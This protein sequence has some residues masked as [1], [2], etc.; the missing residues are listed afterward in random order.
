MK[1]IIEGPAFEGLD[2]LE[3][4]DVIWLNGRVVTVRDVGY[5][6]IVEKNE[7][8]PVDLSGSA[9]FH[10]GPIVRK[11]N[12]RWELI[13]IGPT[14]SMRMEKFSYEFIR[15]TKAKIII[16]KGGMGEETERACI[17]FGSIHCI[18]P[19]GCAVLCARQVER[20]EEVKWEN[21]GMPEAMY[22]MKVR[23]FG[24]LI[25]SIDTKGNNLIRER[26]K[27]LKSKMERSIQKV[28][29]F[30]KDMA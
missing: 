21:L 7:E 24:P 23:E 25:V 2:S 10:A 16:G 17:Q 13:S 26:K 12:G 20:I 14:T 29:D 28:L 4:G 5:R 9:V 8:M 15:R 1:R 18:Y 22:V 30:V 19:G 11:V 3:A 27:I 6:L